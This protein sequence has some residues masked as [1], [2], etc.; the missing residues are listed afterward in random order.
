MEIKSLVGLT[1]C[2]ICGRHC[3][4][5]A[6]GCE[7]GKTLVERLRNGIPV[8]PDAIREEFKQKDGGE[9]HRGHGHEHGGGHRHHE[10]HE[11]G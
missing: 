6:P 8:D 10:H 7:R 9:G 3:P 11:N 4:I 1:N 2:P 5:E